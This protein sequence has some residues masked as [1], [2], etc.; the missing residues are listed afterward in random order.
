MEELK[1]GLPSQRPDLCKEIK[2]EQYERALRFVFAEELQEVLVE[3]YNEVG[4]PIGRNKVTKVITFLRNKR[5]IL[6]ENSK[7]CSL[8][9]NKYY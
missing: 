7:K 3:V 4:Y 5:M 2:V 8:N 6:Q 9:P 1:V